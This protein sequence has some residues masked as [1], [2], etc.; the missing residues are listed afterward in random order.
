MLMPEMFLEHFASVR[1]SAGD[2][3]TIIYSPPIISGMCDYCQ[4]DGACIHQSENDKQGNPCACSFSG[5]ESCDGCGDSCEPWYTGLEI[6]GQRA[7]TDS[8]MDTAETMSYPADGSAV[9]AELQNSQS[10]GVDPAILDRAK[11]IL[12][13][14]RFRDIGDIIVSLTPPFEWETGGA[15][16]LLWNTKVGAFS[17]G[18]SVNVKDG[19]AALLVGRSGES[20]DSF[21]PGNH[22]IS[23]ENCTSLKKDCRLPAQ[24]FNMTVVSGSLFYFSTSGVSLPF[25]ITGPTRSGKMTSV[26]GKA[27][28]AVSSPKELVKHVKS[29]GEQ[30]DTTAF[31]RFISESL[32]SL[33]K[34]G[35]QQVEAANLKSGGTGIEKAISN[36]FTELGLK[37]VKVDIE[38]AGDPRPEDMFSAMGQIQGIGTSREQMMKLVEMAKSIRERNPSAG[39][40]AASHGSNPSTVSCPS[41]GSPNPSTGKF[42]GKCG[43]PI[44]SK[45]CQKCGNPV[46]SGSKFCGTCGTKLM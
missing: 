1:S 29:P 27:T 39:N 9:A 40:T 3:H 13:G 25:A 5:P 22:V 8:L 42:C 14:G 16:A 6:P 24:G 46:T 10:A 34:S 36:S 35:L 18:M 32:N 37:L 23:M 2:S 7:L 19:Q 20:G 33:L 31:D 44:A 17:V 26:R 43:K 11:K 45:S 21:G 38:Y 28:C 30:K 4:V 41:C 12:A 15:P